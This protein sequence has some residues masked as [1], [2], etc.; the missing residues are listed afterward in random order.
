MRE[1]MAPRPSSSSHTIL[2]HFSIAAQHLALPKTRGQ[3]RTE[4][5]ATMSGQMLQNRM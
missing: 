5:G 4:G 3:M 1:T 2:H